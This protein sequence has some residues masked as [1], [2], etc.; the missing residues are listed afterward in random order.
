MSI[1][2]PI[3]DML[4]RIRNGI[5]RVLRYRGYSEL[6]IGRSNDGLKFMKA[7]GFIKNYK[8][9]GRAKAW[10]VEGFSEVRREGAPVIRRSQR[11]S[12]SERRVYTKKDAY[13]NI[14]TV[15]V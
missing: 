10:H 15:L 4:T 12:A 2:D 5:M 11:E 1:S 13:S 3:A 8:D 9:Y 14:L 7:E 6:Q